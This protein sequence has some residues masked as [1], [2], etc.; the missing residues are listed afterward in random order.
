MIST[1]KQLM[2]IA[3]FLNI[4]FA[5]QTKKKQISKPQAKV[6]MGVP[7]DFYPMPQEVAEQKVKTLPIG[8]TA[9]NFRLPGV[10][11]RFY[12]VQSFE[13]SSVLMVIFT[14]N[15]CPEAQAYEARIMALADDYKDEVQV[16][17]ISSNS[18]RN[19]QPEM[20]SISDLGDSFEDMKLR[21]LD[22]GY[23]FPYLYD[24]DTQSAAL[25][26]GPVATP[27]VFLFDKSRKLKYQGR[28]DKDVHAGKAGDVRA[29]IDAILLGVEILEPNTSVKGC[30]ILWEWNRTEANALNADWRA[31]EV[32][33][34]T[35]GL[36]GLRILMNHDSNK[37]W[38][39]NIWAS[40]CP[41]CRDE[42]P[43]LIATHRMFQHRDFELITISIDKAD[44]MEKVL[45]MLKNN[46][47]AVSNFIYADD[48]NYDLISAI[49]REWNGTIPYT[50]LVGPDG[51]ISYR[52]HGAIDLFELRKAIVDHPK[53]GRK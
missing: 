32:K 36:E 11:G 5:C 34:N 17:A 46:H 18:P 13:K 41:P 44:R 31:K 12:T 4:L 14:S 43:D 21:A 27:H 29:A 20:Y 30:E 10:D 52:S 38:L 3:L 45:E 33:L 2:L 35:L 50:I 26:Y 16:V 25:D 48:L 23:K 9:P 7:G 39:V 37:L 1:V 47:A 8:A 24:G 6:E 15:H 28:L 22:K 42:L 51:N 40:W 53:M 19:A 49:D